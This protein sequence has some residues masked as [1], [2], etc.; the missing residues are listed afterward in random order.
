MTFA[1]RGLLRAGSTL[2]GGAT[3][4]I[5]DVTERCE[6]KLCESAAVRMDAGFADGKRKEER[7]T[8]YVVRLKC[9]KSLDRLAGKYLTQPRGP[10]WIK[11]VTWCHELVYEAG[12]WEKARRVVVVVERLFADNSGIIIPCSENLRQGKS[13]ISCF[14]PAS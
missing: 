12:F 7:G 11:P 2:V 8:G 13:A 10:S 4:F 14:V 9:N 3:E 6:G 5:K 1:K